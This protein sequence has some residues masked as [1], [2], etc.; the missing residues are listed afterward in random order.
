MD[1][2]HLHI[3]LSVLSKCFNVK[4]DHFAQASQHLCKYVHSILC[5]P[6]DSHL[7]RAAGFCFERLV[8]FDSF[9]C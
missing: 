5:V 7:R 9:A 8:K 2:L 3:H 4:N 6:T 1:N